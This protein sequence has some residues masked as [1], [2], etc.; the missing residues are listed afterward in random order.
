MLLALFSPLQRP[1]QLCAE[2]FSFR[3]AN[4]SSAGGVREN[5]G[6]ERV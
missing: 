1:E 6:N 2:S 3:A 5:V 4:M